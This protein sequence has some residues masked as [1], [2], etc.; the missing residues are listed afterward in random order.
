MTAA[1]PILRRVLANTGVLVG[2]RTAN[3]LISLAYLALAARALGVADVGA[4]LLIN[5]F[6]QLVGDVVKFNAWQ[7][8]L[9]YG[10][11]PLAAGDRA[12]FHQVLR[13]TLFLD[14]ASSLA[15][16]A[17]AICLALL[18]G[19]RLGWDM[20]R[21]G[22]AALYCLSILVMT[23][24]TPIGLLRLFD[25]FDLIAAQAP[26]G[27]TLRLAGCGL[28]FLTGASL[29]AF[30]AIWAAGTV[31]A[32]AYLATA[33]HAEMRKRGLTHGFRWLGPLSAGLPGAWKFAWATNLGSTL[34]V[35]FTHALTLAVGAIAG[36]APAALWRVGR[37]VADAVAKPAR[38][39]IPALYPELARLRATDGEKAM[40]RLASQVGLVGGGVGAV[41]LL[42]TVA[43]RPLL[44]L[45]MGPDFAPAA[46]IMVWQMAAAAV[47]ICA[48]PLEPMLI[49][50]GRPGDVVKVRIVVG[51]ALLAALPWAIGTFGLT[52]AGAALLAAMLAL[53][54]GMYT[55][56]QLGSHKAACTN[57]PVRA[58]DGE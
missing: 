28:A 18:I 53:A 50:L 39:L 16:A 5:A 9:Q 3:A 43:G 47:G 33:A 37:Q 48:L 57:V 51:L 20:N 17:V 8:V 2:G 45:V 55:M 1:P 58:K 31:A 11:G 7:T 10:A 38:L 44:T 32:F 42:A 12:G 15:G 35:A 4:L 19:E 27:S 30:L 14:I 22:P 21:N 26:V 13:F 6:A 49:S 46:G 23:P 34:E 36:P 52:G 25:R 24:S 41:L 54:A 29:P 56:L 40:R